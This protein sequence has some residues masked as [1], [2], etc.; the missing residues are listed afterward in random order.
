MNLDE[1]KIF[2]EKRDRFAKANG[3]KIEEID[4]GYA[5][6]SMKVEEEHLNGADVAH[7]GAIFTLADFAFALSSNSY[8]TISLSI[9]SSISFIN[10]AKK[11]EILTA[12]AKEIEKNHKLGCYS[13][14]V[15]NEN[16]KIIAIFQG[17]VYRKNQELRSKN[18]LG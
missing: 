18:D 5:K 8:G 12:I 9:N 15:T 3:I 1:L 17:M 6:V 2:F 10:G 11:G 4:K 13:V 14:E 16:S 7:G